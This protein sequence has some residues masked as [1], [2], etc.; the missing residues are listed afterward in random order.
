MNTLAN[1]IGPQK[2]LEVGTV[3]A[4]GATQLAAVNASKFGGGSSVQAP[5]TPQQTTNNSVSNSFSFDIS[6]GS[7][8]DTGQ[9]T[10]V[11]ENYFGEDGVLFDKNSAQAAALA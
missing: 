7:N 8:V 4:T 5:Q 10:Q 2:W 1:T 6:G 9:I 11:L 3:A